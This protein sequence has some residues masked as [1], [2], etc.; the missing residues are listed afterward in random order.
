MI[1][2]GNGYNDQENWES[3][4]F[5]LFKGSEFSVTSEKDAVVWSTV[6]EPQGWGVRAEVEELSDVL[7]IPRCCRKASEPPF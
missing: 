1:E 6:L 4:L 7:R 2:I 5:F 3:Y